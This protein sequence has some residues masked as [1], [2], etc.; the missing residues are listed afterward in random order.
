MIT[1]RELAASLMPLVALREK[2]GL[3]V[4]LIDIEDIYDEFSFGQKSPYAVKDFLAYANSNWKKKPRFV[5][6]AGDASLDP[7]N[8]LGFGDLDLVPTRRSTLSSWKRPP[9]TGFLI[10]IKTASPT[11]QPADC[12]R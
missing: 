9:M 6:L 4:A 12:P 3:R 7:K 11:L 5:L 1:T 10:S 8:Y 2:R